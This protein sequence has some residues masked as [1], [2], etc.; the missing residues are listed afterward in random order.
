MA[1]RTTSYLLPL[2]TQSVAAGFPSPADEY[3][4]TRIN[5]NDHLI[6][7]PE[8]S[9]ILKTAGHALN[10]LGIFDGDYLVVDKSL[11]PAHQN[12]VI[13]ILNGQLTI[14]QILKMPPTGWALQGGLETEPH[15]IT[16]ETQIWG[17]V[18]WVLH[19]V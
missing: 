8:A 9:F 1:L 19:K 18:K 4:E 2:A 10:H 7:H 5:L 12:I 13:V 3:S 11:T 6:A 14:K 15:A 17:V 16:E